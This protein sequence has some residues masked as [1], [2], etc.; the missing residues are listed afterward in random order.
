MRIG[1]LSKRSGL[2]RDTLRFYEK[3]GL[4]HSRPGAAATNNYRDYPKDTLIQLEQIADAQAAG[5]S[6]ADVILFL[7]QLEAADSDDFDGEAFLQARIDEI[8]Y[9]IKRSE[10]FLDSLRR[11]QQVLATPPTES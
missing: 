11:A 5:M 8:T 2:S 3:Q 4:I 9:R 10:R 6:I 1:E 7:S